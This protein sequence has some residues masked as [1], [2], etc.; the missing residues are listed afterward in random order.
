MTLVALDTELIEEVA[1]RLL[2]RA[3]NKAAL[4]RLSVKRT[5]LLVPLLFAVACSGSS[6]A[7]VACYE[8]DEAAATYNA[9]IDAARA[10]TSTNSDYAGQMG[11]VAGRLANIPVDTPE[12]IR[13]DAALISLH[14]G[15]ARVAALAGD[16]VEITSEQIAIV[17]A[18][19]DARPACDAK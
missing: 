9:A 13:S 17:A 16:V 2:L 19:A 11:K 10:G 5:I 7:T 3:P 14:A 4:E 1:A 8:M 12:P 15:R 18:F 6:K